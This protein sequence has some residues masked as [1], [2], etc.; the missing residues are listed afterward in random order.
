MRTIAA[1]IMASSFVALIWV[2]HEAIIISVYH[3]PGLTNPTI[4][5]GLHPELRDM[6]FAM[7]LVTAVSAYC[8]AM[9]SW[10]ERR[11]AEICSTVDTGRTPSR[12]TEPATVRRLKDAIRSGNPAA[13]LKYAKQPA[14]EVIDD[15]YLTPLELADLYENQPVVDALR[16]A[17]MKHARYRTPPGQPITPPSSEF[18][19]QKNSGGPQ[20]TT[21]RRP[22]A[23]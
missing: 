9:V 6:L 11:L 20:P 5:F 14:L 16:A 21:G 15:H 1:L 13:V 10:T 23:R 18:A 17:M 19:L 4:H 12:V 3:P 2:A 8:F 7:L 22:A